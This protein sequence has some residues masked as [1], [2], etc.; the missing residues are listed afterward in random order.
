MRGNILGCVDLYCVGAF[1]VGE[2]SLGS[3]EMRWV[4]SRG[5]TV[6]EDVWPSGWLHIF[7]H[8]KR[9]QKRV[10]SNSRRRMCRSS[11]RS[12]PASPLLM[13]RVERAVG[14]VSC[15]CRP[16]TSFHQHHVRLSRLHPIASSECRAFCAFNDVRL[17]RV[18]LCRAFPWELP[19]Y[20]KKISVAN[21][22][23]LFTLS[24]LSCWW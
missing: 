4:C 24:C 22:C 9:S 2:A 14:D 1:Y 8:P 5:D 23:F 16:S 6:L 12:R 10:N 13:C 11:S 17:L 15:S 7:Q 20:D 3:D 21:L 18:V 19:P